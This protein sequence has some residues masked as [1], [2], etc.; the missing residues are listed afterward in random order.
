VDKDDIKEKAEERVTLSKA[1]LWLLRCA[2][3]TG[4]ISAL[5]HGLELLHELGI[6]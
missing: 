4:V 6:F 5:S 1:E 3:A 2:A